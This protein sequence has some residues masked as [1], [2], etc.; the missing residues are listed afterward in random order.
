MKLLSKEEFLKAL[1]Q[2]PS[3]FHKKAASPAYN[4]YMERV[5]MFDNCSHPF[6]MEEYLDLE[7]KY[8]F[9]SMP[10]MDIKDCPEWFQEVF[11]EHGQSIALQRPGQGT[12]ARNRYHDPLRT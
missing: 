6:S 5:V 2:D 10:F 1:E 12:A 8:L 9:E 4:N 3:L 11:T 7:K